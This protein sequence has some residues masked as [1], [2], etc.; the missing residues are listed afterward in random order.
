MT[1]DVAHPGEVRDGALEAYLVDPESLPTPPGIVLEI[2]RKSDDPDAS[3]PDLAKLVE[4]DAAMA[5]RFVQM[6]NSG[7]FSPLHEINSVS[8]ALGV[9][10]LRSIRLLALGASLQSL[11]PSG[12]MTNASSAARHRSVISAAVARRFA[13]PS[14]AA[15]ADDAF[16]SALLGHLGTIVVAT[17]KPDL[18]LR[19]VDEDR[20]WIPIAGQEQHFGFH[21]DDLAAELIDSWGLPDRLGEAIRRRHHPMT[22]D[23][24]TLEA[25]LRIGLLAEDV[26][27]SADPEATRELFEMA[28]RFCGLDEDACR[29]VL[30]ETEAEIAETAQLLTFEIPPGAGHAELLAEA[31]RRMNELSVDTM[32]AQQH[33][34]QAQNQLKERAEELEVRSRIDALTGLLN[35]GALDQL[36]DDEMRRRM[37][38]PNT[39]LLGLL[40]FDI[41]HFK[42]VNDTYGHLVG[43]EILRAVGAAVQD[44]SR[45]GEY[46]ARYGG[47]EFCLLMPRT[48]IHEM[49]LA[50]ERMRRTVEEL[51]VET[52]KGLLS[53][54]VSVGG[55]AVRNPDPSDIG[56]QKLLERADRCLYAAKEGGR[57]RAEIDDRDR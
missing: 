14:A 39:D 48:E 37:V 21:F 38:A 28:E 22:D 35:R 43:D 34:E 51:K 4:Q 56:N 49:Q 33:N 47:E 41:D 19:H 26:L 31:T 24:G 10:G 32:R 36:I 20:N 1:T 23:A 9:V 30:L 50:A 42:A 18:Y 45:R 7:L 27:I 5:A 2:I 15:D 29:E 16:L 44:A 8:R 53:V 3:I 6:A 54:T 46:V 17:T 55:A 13:T 11:L 40:I 12:D 52:G 57:N 25:C